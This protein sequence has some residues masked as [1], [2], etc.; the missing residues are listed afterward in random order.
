MAADPYAGMA[1][2][3]M[4][5]A[6]GL[7]RLGH[8]VSY[9]ESTMMWPYDP[10]AGERV[11]DP[12]YAIRYLGRVCESFGLGDRWAY[13]R[14]HP[15]LEWVGPRGGQAETLLTGA[16]AVLNITGATRLARERL[17][18]GRVVYFGTD[19][20]YHE[21]AFASGAPQTRWL[22][23]EHDDVV[24]YGENVGNDDCSLPALPKLRS[25]T[26]QP[27]LLDLWRDGPPTRDVFTTVSNWRQPG[28]D[29]DYN[30]RTYRW[31]KHHEFLKFVS[32]P[33]NG[34]PPVELATGL[35]N[36]SARDRRKLQS[37]GWRLSDAHSFTT[38]PWRYRD[39]ILASRGEFTVAK[40]QYVAPRTGWFSERSACYLAAGRP[41]VSQDTGFGNSLP[42]GT[43]L[44]AVD[45]PEEARDAL[46]Q[47]NGDYGR[48][49]RA[50]REIAEEFFGAERVLAKVIEDLGL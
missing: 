39:Y 30:G 4:Q 41:V 2:M 37:N 43:G 18:A 46:E 21:L 11:R 6:A 1:W 35:V 15:A 33:S 45:T 32:V 29:I 36:L 12:S 19:P 42:T 13:R 25:K 24:T 49:S 22:E 27:V 23:D 8:D 44:F 5:I 38:D 28:R 47:I 17:D 40:D 3:H 14:R 16:D 20:G 7:L 34:G 9:V 31:S 10:E 26:R 48:H 50:A